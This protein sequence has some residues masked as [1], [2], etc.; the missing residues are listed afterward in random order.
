MYLVL[1]AESLATAAL[2]LPKNLAPDMLKTFAL[3]PRVP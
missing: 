3:A 2:E 1:A